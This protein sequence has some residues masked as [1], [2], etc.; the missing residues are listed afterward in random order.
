MSTSKSSFIQV[1]FLSG[2]SY[3]SPRRRKKGESGKG[4]HNMSDNISPSTS[5]HKWEFKS[6]L[7]ILLEECY[8]KYFDA[9][10]ISILRHSPFKQ[11][12]IHL[13]NVERSSWPPHAKGYSLYFSALLRLPTYILIIIVGIKMQIYKFIQTFNLFSDILF[14]KNGSSPLTRIQVLLLQFPNA[15]NSV[16]NIGN[17]LNHL[18]NRWV[19]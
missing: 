14:T 13:S 4:I 5:F 6:H 9:E 2:S 1:Q 12:F 3:Q 15:W 19:T 17:S 10:T 18:F 11:I 8:L 7:Y 16:E